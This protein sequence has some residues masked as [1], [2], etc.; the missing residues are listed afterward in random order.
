MGNKLI[1]HKEFSRRQFIKIAGALATMAYL[2]S[3]C[4]VSNSDRW[5]YVLPTRKLG[6]TG[7]DVTM[8]CLGGGPPPTP[9]PERPNF[10]SLLTTLLMEVVV[11]LRLQDPMELNLNTEEFLNHI[12][13]KSY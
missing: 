4:R 12:V 3:S 2:P 7:L 1:N 10:E 9:R 13:M 6:K 5:G 11:F 8:F